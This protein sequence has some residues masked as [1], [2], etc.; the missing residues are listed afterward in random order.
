MQ[1]DENGDERL[2]EEEEV[3]QH[4]IP[5]YQLTQYYHNELAHFDTYI[6]FIRR[7][8]CGAPGSIP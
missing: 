8:L 1:I 4:Q 5:P 2:E 6:I 7:A 3:Q